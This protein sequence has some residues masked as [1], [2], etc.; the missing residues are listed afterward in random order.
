MYRRAMGINVCKFIFNFLV[1]ELALYA[2]S[3]A[4]DEEEVQV[5]IQKNLS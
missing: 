5:F 3:V 2:N 4:S 1:W